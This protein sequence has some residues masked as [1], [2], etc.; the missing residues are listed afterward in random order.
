MCR[1]KYILNKASCLIGKNLTRFCR[2]LKINFFDAP[3]VRA[4][5]LFKRLIQKVIRRL[6]CI[7]TEKNQNFK[8]GSNQINHSSIVI[9]KAK[10]FNFTTLEAHFVSLPNTPLKT[11]CTSNWNLKLTYKKV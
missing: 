7:Q 10:F 5:G 4:I 2:E 6:P 3:V 11:T 9:F 1:K 8:K